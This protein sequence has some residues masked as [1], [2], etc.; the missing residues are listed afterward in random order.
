MKIKT[1]VATVCRHRDRPDAACRRLAR[2]RRCGRVLRVH[3]HAPTLC[4]DCRL[5]LADKREVA[6]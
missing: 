5:R 3:D 6:L 4:N 1:T 2:C